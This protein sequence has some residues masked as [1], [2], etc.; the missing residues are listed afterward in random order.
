MPLRHIVPFFI[1][2]CALCASLAAQGLTHE[3]TVPYP[4]KSMPSIS[5]DGSLFA[6]TL[7][8]TSI[9]RYNGASGSIRDTVITPFV[10]NPERVAF[11]GNTLYVLSGSRNDSLVMYRCA[12]SRTQCDSTP[13]TFRFTK[14]GDGDFS[15]NVTRV[16]LYAV[17]HYPH[18]MLSSSIDGSRSGYSAS[19]YFGQCQDIDTTSF[20]PVSLVEGH[21]T[22]VRWSAD[23]RAFTRTYYRSMFDPQG[24]PDYYGS[25]YWCNETYNGAIASTMEYYKDNHG[26]ES[27][28][29]GFA[30][31]VHSGALHNIVYDTVVYDMSEKRKIDLPSKNGRILASIYPPL[32]VL[33]I[34]KG[35]GGDVL[36]AYH[37]LN[38]TSHDLDTVPSCTDVWINGVDAIMYLLDTVSKTLTRY[39]I[40]PYPIADTIIISVDKARQKIRMPVS[41]TVQLFSAKNVAHR[42]EWSFGDMTF[43]T[44]Q[45]TTTLVSAREGVQIPSVVVV[46]TVSHDTLRATGGGVTCYRPG[47]NIMVSD[48]TTDK[49][50]VYGCSR[51][52]TG[53]MIG[54][55]TTLHDYQIPTV[56]ADAS[57]A[58]RLIGDTSAFGTYFSRDSMR[59]VLA[60]PRGAYTYFRYYHTDSEMNDLTL[61]DTLTVDNAWPEQGEYRARF[62]NK[63]LYNAQQQQHITHFRVRQ[64]EHYVGELYDGIWLHPSRNVSKGRWLLRGTSN[65][66][67]R[68][69]TPEIMY[70]D[71]SY[72]STL[73]LTEGVWLKSIDLQ[74]MDTLFKI[75]RAFVG[76]PTESIQLDPT[77]II[78]NNGILKRSSYWERKLPFSFSDGIKVFRMDDQ[79]SLVL[80]KNV[81]NIASVI[82]HATGEVIEDIGEGFGTPIDG[83]YDRTRNLL[84]VVDTN[85]LLSS[86][87]IDTPV[88]VEN[89]EVT[90][91]EQRQLQVRQRSRGRYEI[92]L[93]DGTNDLNVYDLTGRCVYTVAVNEQAIETE[94]ELPSG[95]RSGLYLIVARSD[96]S[97]ST[98]TMVHWR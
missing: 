60:E 94:F 91:T 30:E 39:R 52:G 14:W 22:T 74:T 78:T 76:Y 72:R 29:R 13:Y 27:T 61:V 57:Y 90:H 33:K 2:F 37:Y 67:I 71:A 11:C 31:A 41:A 50:V 47:K 42:L 48:D 38:G 9:V 82:D 49:R 23:L 66:S 6:R 95:L 93:P 97:T 92:T 45:R 59:L 98:A 25:G 26:G 87:A 69:P 88:S 46:D 63:A 21:L 4:F 86:Y 62:L 34:S 53:L 73:L 44:D 40:A 19:Y 56:P 55:T 8:T 3:W 68:V 77:T 75:D 12:A 28:P 84:H 85:N 36:S 89:E 35:A 1:A 43:K 20:T 51:S 58:P 81:N 18:V 32:Y 96:R 5:S 79:H 7:D 24:F 64:I 65:S 83:V 17:P 54:G 16:G 15:R 70:A 10:E 80:R